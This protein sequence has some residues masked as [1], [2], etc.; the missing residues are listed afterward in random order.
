[1]HHEAS[2]LSR[3][4]H[5]LGLATWLGGNVFGQV[6]LNP[7]VQRISSKR[8]RGRVVN[9]SWGRFTAVNA[10]AMAATVLTWRKGGIRS[11]DGDLG[12]E[13]SSLV[14]LKNLLLGGAVI[15]SVASGLLGARIA[16]QDWESAPPV[17]SGTDPAP[18]TPQ[19]AATAQRLIK[20]FGSSSIALL[21]GVVA[22][23]AAIESNSRSPR[24]IVQRFLF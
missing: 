7:T 5:E 11:A 3:I 20:V 16:R 1:M 4:T 24:S 2:T 10:A 8:E 14:S 21:A 9:E 23:S 15:T 6:A 12:V 17:E 18:E 22:T 19:E 13:A